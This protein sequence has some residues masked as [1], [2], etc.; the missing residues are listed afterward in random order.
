[1]NKLQSVVSSV[2]EITKTY[3]NTWAHFVRPFM[4]G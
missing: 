4:C 2:T 3:T 1:M